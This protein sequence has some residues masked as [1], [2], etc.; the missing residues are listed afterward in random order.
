MSP[1]I[2][3]ADGRN[4]E[5]Q[6][7]CSHFARV[8]IRSEPGWKLVERPGSARI[9]CD[10]MIARRRSTLL[11]KAGARSRSSGK[12]LQDD[13][14]KL[15][16]QGSDV[17]TVEALDE[18]HTIHDERDAPPGRRLYRAAHECTDLSG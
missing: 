18:T 7:V 14:C 8:S 11:F 2:A 5:L 9:C 3:S 6:T 12:R 4:R 15:L 16:S 1:F 13:V 17:R 10:T